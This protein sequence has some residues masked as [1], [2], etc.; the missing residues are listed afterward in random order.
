[1]LSGVT[2]ENCGIQIATYIPFNFCERLKTIGKNETMFE[3]GERS[4]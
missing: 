3:Y 4:M 1:M 2:V